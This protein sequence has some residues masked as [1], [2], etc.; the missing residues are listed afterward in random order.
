MGT[1]T[2]EVT[3]FMG[4]ERRTVGAS[5]DE[6]VDALVYANNKVNAI[7]ELDLID[8]FTVRM[9]RTMQVRKEN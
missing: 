6:H 5:F 7:I 3:L 4:E 9:E 1:F 2:V 8:D